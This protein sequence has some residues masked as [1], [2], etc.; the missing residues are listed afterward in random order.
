MRESQ[1]P[2]SRPYPTPT[3][4]AGQTLA[5]PMIIWNFVSSYTK[6]VDSARHLG[7]KLNAVAA[8]PGEHFENLQAEDEL[9]RSLQPKFP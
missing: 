2:G 4:S 3:T 8:R 5:I 6:G 1:K 7:Y 9:K